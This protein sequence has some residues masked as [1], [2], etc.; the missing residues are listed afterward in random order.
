MHRG[1]IRSGILCDS[2]LDFDASLKTW[3]I[4][5]FFR[6]LCLLGKSG[7]KIGGGF[8][9]RIASAVSGSFDNYKLQELP[10]TLESI[11]RNDRF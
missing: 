5:R 10:C 3:P 6:P 7:D 11:L 9:E 1:E 4:K 2:N 8:G